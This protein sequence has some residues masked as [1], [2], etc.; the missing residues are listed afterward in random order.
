MKAENL[1]QK[2]EELKN[3]ANILLDKAKKAEND[4]KGL[5]SLNFK[6]KYLQYKN[7]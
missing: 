6:L 3:S 1:T 7:N 5:I 2:A 4:L